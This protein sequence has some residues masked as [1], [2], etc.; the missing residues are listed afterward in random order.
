[1]TT[2]DPANVSPWYLRNINQALAL[3][4]ATGQVYIRTDTTI[5]GN[6]TIPGTVE[7]HVTELGNVDLSGNTLP[8][9]VYQGTTPWQV[10]GNVTITDQGYPWN[11]QVAQGKVSGV[12]GLSISGYGPTIGT[13][14]QPAW[15]LGAYTFLN[16]AQ[17]LR[18]WSDSASD[19]NVSVLISGLDSSYNLLTE[20]VVLTNGSTG[21]LTTNNFFRV[22]NLALTRTPQN[23]GNV[24]VGTSDKTNTL[25]FIGP[26]NDGSSGR[27]QMTVYTVPAGYT[28]Y[29]TQSNWY[30]NQTGSQTALYRSWTQKQGGPVNIVLTFPMQQQYNSAKIVPRPYTEKT[31][32]QWQVA[33][34]S[35]TSRIGGQIEGYLIAN[36]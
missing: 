2:P 36:T 21:V 9:T 4:E 13:A 5:T 16:S 11:L 20:T 25:A 3:N 17:Q 8:A 6:V 24:H 14:F 12:T 29:L 7:A 10:T 28:F 34:S 22:N 1:M 15:E 32:I 31:D 27:S 35:G 33:S 23:V 19:T 18:V 26:I 30:T